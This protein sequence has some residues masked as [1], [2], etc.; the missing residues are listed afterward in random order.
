MS[1]PLILSSLCSSCL[2]L[3]ILSFLIFF[4]VISFFSST[5]YVRR[6]PRKGLLFFFYSSFF[7]YSLRYQTLPSPTLPTHTQSLFLFCSYFLQRHLGSRLVE[8]V[9]NAVDVPLPCRQCEDGERVRHRCRVGGGGSK[10]GGVVFPPTAENVFFTLLPPAVFLLQTT[11]YL[12]FLSL[13]QPHTHT[14]HGH[15]TVL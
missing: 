11:A 3:F 15:K 9:F 14:A 6:M 8:S 12:L 5:S 7:F 1:K 10:N 4:F 2:H 13:T